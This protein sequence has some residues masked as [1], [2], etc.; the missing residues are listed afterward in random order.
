M[1]KIPVAR[2]IGHAYGFGFGNF[3]TAVAIC[4]LPYLLLAAAG[5]FL[6]AGPLRE[7]FTLVFSA[8]SERIAEV[9]TGDRN[10]EATRFLQ[11]ILPA[12]GAIYRYGILFFLLGTLLQAMVA[13]GLTRASMGL[14]QRGFFFFSLEAP[15]WKLFGAWLATYLIMYAAMAVIAFVGIMLGVAIGIGLAQVDSRAFIVFCA[16]L[17]L[18]ALSLMAWIAVRL[19]FFLPAIIVSEKKLDVLR[20]WN[21]SEGNVLRVLGIYLSFLP[22]LL[23]LFLAGSFAKI[24]AFLAFVP[25][26][27]NFPERLTDNAD[28]ITWTRVVADMLPWL[29]PLVAATL[30]VQILL[31][32]M[33]YAA[34][35]RAYRD[36]VATDIASQ[37][38]HT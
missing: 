28:W 19:N 4:W 5:V 36:I 1:R 34:T 33:L 35:A 13:V 10:E 6:L 15:V 23:V 18:A 11:T 21:L 31:S 24:I 29:G 25:H 32:A 16:V 17:V 26:W 7:F 27:F 8:L 2:S 12:Y 3:G 9:G 20:S 22:V 37:T 38:E 14:E 30:L